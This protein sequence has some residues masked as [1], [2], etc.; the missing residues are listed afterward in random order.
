MKLQEQKPASCV[1]FEADLSAFVDGE[2]DTLDANKLMHHVDGCSRCQ[3][4]I[5]QLGQMGRMHRACYSEEDILGALDGA[6]IF[7]NI[8]SDL[9]H[10]KSGKIA[11][12]FYQIGKAYLLKGFARGREAGASPDSIRHVLRP[13]T[14]PLAIETAKMKTGRI[15]R[16]IEGLSA[17][18]P[19][20]HKTLKRAGSFFRTTRRRQ[21][22]C[23]ELG[24]RF[25]EES[26]AIDP[27]RAEPRLYLGAYFYAG[28]KKYQE[29]KEQ[30]RKV[31]SLP[32]VSEVNRAD[33]LI[34][35]G[36]LYT[37]EY[38]YAEAKACFQ[39]VERSGVI[40]QY[41]RFYRCLIF[42]AV[43]C[44]KLGEFDEAMDVFGRIA[45]SFPKRIDQ[46][47][48]EIWDMHSFQNVVQ[49]HDG[50]RESLRNRI[51][52]LFAS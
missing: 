13:R 19:V 34:N 6:E 30:F 44:A 18:M 27:E 25:I 11:D 7:Q 36:A 31:L 43:T 45:A 21:D 17:Q 15:F 10:E 46:I 12:L 14:R 51:P 49:M 5:E 38:Q 32:N 16:E 40:K 52:V 37:I 41:P 42:L 20:P 47:R 23:L 3:E 1:E 8:A 50:F 39:E 9:L 29:A 35:L 48:C 24:R 26:L 33:A 28:M 22:G 4:L 2:L